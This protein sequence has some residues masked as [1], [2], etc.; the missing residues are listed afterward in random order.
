M[1]IYICIVLCKCI[2]YMYIYVHK[3]VCRRIRTTKTYG[4]ISIVRCSA[5]E[6]GHATNFTLTENMFWTQRAVF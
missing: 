5:L 4:D 2:T 6:K 3:N 1:T